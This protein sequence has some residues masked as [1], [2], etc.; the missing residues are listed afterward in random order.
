VDALPAGTPSSGAAD[1]ARNL[2]ATVVAEVLAENRHRWETLSP[3]DRGRVEAMAREIAG[4]LLEPSVEQLAAAERDGDAKRVDLAREVLGL[5][6]VRRQ[7]RAGALGL[8]P[9]R[10]ARH[11]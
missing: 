7:G 6:R 10:P 3:A 2:G 8:V 11:Q 1:E 4:R 9:P 5:T